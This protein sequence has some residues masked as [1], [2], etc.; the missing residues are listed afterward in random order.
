MAISKIA[1][2]ISGISS[3]A[4][5]PGQAIAGYTD[6]TQ[7]SLCL[8]YKGVDLQTTRFGVSTQIYYWLRV[9]RVGL[10]RLAAYELKESLRTFRTRTGASVASVVHCLFGNGASCSNFYRRLWVASQKALNRSVALRFPLF[11][12]RISMCRSGFAAC[13]AFCVSSRLPDSSDFLRNL[14]VAWNWA[15]A[16]ASP[17]KPACQSQPDKTRLEFAPS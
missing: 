7:V 1:I 3:G 2:S 15:C 10:R 4:A 17:S 6:K 5:E 8:L 11:R 13:Y 12:S 16:G 14:L 9:K